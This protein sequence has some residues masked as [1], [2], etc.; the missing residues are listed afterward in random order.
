MM[1]LKNYGKILKSKIRTSKTPRSCSVT[2]YLL[3][4]VINRNILNNR[5]SVQGSFKYFFL[6]EYGCD[7]LC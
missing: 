5:I 4:S 6:R 1:Q 7:T 3:T 2:K